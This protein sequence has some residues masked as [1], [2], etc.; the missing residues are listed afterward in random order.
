MSKTETQE[1][2]F[3]F[4]TKTGQDIA[5][6]VKGSLDFLNQMYDSFHREAQA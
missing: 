4:K 6:P 5:C 3:L 2:M 1:K